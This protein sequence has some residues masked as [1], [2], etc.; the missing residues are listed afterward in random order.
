MRQERGGW[1]LMDD[2]G[3]ARPPSAGIHPPN[4]QKEI[5]PDSDPRRHSCF[6]LASKAGVHIVL[7]FSGNYWRFA[8]FS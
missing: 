2:L 7:V 8:S 4:P 1:D 5:R 6:A 3:P